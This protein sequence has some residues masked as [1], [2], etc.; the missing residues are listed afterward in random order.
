M[1]YLIHLSMAINNGI[2]GDNLRGEP[3]FE[4]NLLSAFI[5]SGETIYTTDYP[6]PI[7]NSGQA[8]D[9]LKTYTEIG[10]IK[11]TVYFSHGAP[12]HT[13]IYREA[14]NYI[15]Q[16]FN[17][18]DPPI[19][20][21]IKALMENANLLITTSF[22]NNLINLKNDYG[23]S[24]VVL[25]EGPAVPDIVYRGED[26]SPYYMLWSYRNFF[27]FTSRHPLE[28]KTIFSWCL[29]KLLRYENYR[30]CV[31]VGDFPEHG[32]T[33]EQV[34]EWFWGLG[35]V[36]PLK[37]HKDRVDVFYNVD[38]D[39]MMQLNKHTRVIISPAES[40]GGPPYEAAINGV[41]IVLNEKSFP[42]K[43]SGAIMSGDSVNDFVGHLESLMSDKY[44]YSASKLYYNYVRERASYSAYIEQIKKEIESRN[45]EKT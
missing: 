6:K 41:P 10:G 26:S 43:F 25:I 42:F 22:N 36:A 5:S 18:P 3:R 31:V 14:E 16:Q 17:V 24:N 33:E 12:N 40:A 2:G 8:P 29:S 11:N 30:V 27:Q 1:K 35:C 44:Y 38:W 20:N 13:T 45:W 23:D 32:K 37:N 34:T 4:R 19:R 7:W 21:T 15:I 39:T 28:V 9:N